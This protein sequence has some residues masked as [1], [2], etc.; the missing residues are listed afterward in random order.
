MD[1]GLFL[2]RAWG[3]YMVLSCLILISNKKSIFTLLKK[4]QFDLNIVFTGAFVLVIGVL[5]VVAYTDWSINWR[6]LITL[7]GWITVIKGLLLMYPGYV[8]KF[9]K[10]AVKEN[11]FTVTF[12]IGIVIGIYL[13]YVGYVMY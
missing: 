10:L 9:G 2:A 11:T 4:I 5:Q 1:I 3:L 6:G 8:D 7:L 12:L 13:L